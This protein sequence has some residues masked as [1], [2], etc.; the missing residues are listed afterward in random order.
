MKI[1][2][3]FF[4]SS[5]SVVAKNLQSL[6]IF[7]ES[8]V[9]TLEFIT[10]SVN[11]LQRYLCSLDQLA[12]GPLGS[13]N[14]G[15]VGVNFIKTEGL[16]K[17]SGGWLEAW[18]DVLEYHQP[19]DITYRDDQFISLLVFLFYCFK[20]VIWLFC[21]SVLKNSYSKWSISAGSWCQ[22]PST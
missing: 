8:G 4:K 7:H 14:Q 1:N 22:N 20:N 2:L 19:F 12:W 15:Q 5:Q 10:Q 21:P 6:E 3:L 11:E 18:K 16:F 9:Q 13:R 17:Q